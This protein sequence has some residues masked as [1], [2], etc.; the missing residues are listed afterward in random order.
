MTRLFDE[1]KVSLAASDPIR[2][3]SFGEV[4][5]RETTNE[6]TRWGSGRGVGTAAGPGSER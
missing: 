3:W 2:A 1:L 5:K 4:K 6:G